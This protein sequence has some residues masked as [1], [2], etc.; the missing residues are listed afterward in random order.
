MSHVTICGCDMEAA[1]TR[2]VLYDGRMTTKQQYDSSSSRVASKVVS[3]TAGRQGG[4]LKGRQLLSCVI[5][6][7]PGTCVG[8]MV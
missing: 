5:R 7:M 6:V 4:R 8:M 1:M 2:N 3:G